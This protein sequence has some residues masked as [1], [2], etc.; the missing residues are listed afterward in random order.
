VKLLFIVNSISGGIDKHQTIQK[1]EN[2]LQKEKVIYEIVITNDA[3]SGLKA[4]EKA[5]NEKYSAVVAV[6]GDGTLQSVGAALIGSEIPLG[7]I[8]MGSGNGLARMLKCP[9]NVEAAIQKILN[10]KVQSIDVAKANERVFLNIC[11][12]GFDALISHRFAH[13]E[14]RGFYNYTRLTIQ[15]L[16]KYKSAEYIISFEGQTISEK[17]FLVS[18]CNGN[19]FGNKAYIAPE[20][21][22]NDGLLN[23][24]L[25]KP[26]GI[27]KSVPIAVRLF[28]KKLT[29]SNQ[30]ITLTASH[31]NLKRKD[32]HAFHYHIDGEPMPP[33]TELSIKVLPSLLKVIV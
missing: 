5:K 7:I 19:Q 2:L 23:L 25:L 20:A 32:G 13:T 9:F 3:H 21:K 27:L 16:S 30:T 17:A 6:G 26:F 14:K 4:I 15:S 12:V 24:T 10:G 11:G 28:S 33:S 18:V 8:P 31:F 22:L 1:I 29:V